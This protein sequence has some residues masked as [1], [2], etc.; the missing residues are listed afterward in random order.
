MDWNLEE[1]IVE[2]GTATK[3]QRKEKR[4]VNVSENASW[5]V[6]FLTAGPEYRFR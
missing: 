1:Q 3:K 4:Q 5:S 2:P 6:I